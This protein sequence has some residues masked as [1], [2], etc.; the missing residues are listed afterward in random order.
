MS[1]SAV[2]GAIV[3][4]DLK[5]FSRDR[6][7]MFITIL[8]L[9][10]YVLIYWILPS[11]VDETIEVGVHGADLGPV[12]VVG[13]GEE[14]GLAVTRFSTADEL[15]Q[16]VLGEASTTVALGLDFPTDFAELV[17]SGQRATVRVLITPEVPAEYRQAMTAF[18]KEIAYG[19]AG[20]TAPVALPAQE[21]V[22][23]GE[24]RSGEQVSLQEKMGPMFV[25]F[26]LLVETFALGTLV[27]TELQGR[28]VT[29]ILATPARMSD[30]LTAKTVIGTLL[31]FTQALLLV[32]LIG[33][34]GTS[35]LV[36]VVVLL[37]GSLLVTGIGLIAGSTGKDF[38]GLVFWSMLF[39]IPLMVPAFAALFPGTASTWVRALPT[40]GLVE[41]IIR[42]TAFG[43]GMA[44]VAG[45]LLMLLGWC[46]VAFGAGLLMLRRRVAAL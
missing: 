28:T 11:N 26:I 27:A 41:T 25:F 1:R 38:V 44:D 6:F 18:V 40:Y 33:V 12:L 15:E 39:M 30:F 16:A 23:L 24:D 17:A 35:P 31:T 36:L 10:F 37:L 42:A 29:A 2:I 34:L 5:E 4:K 43:D 20:D 45:L 22:I 8:G 13:A 7:Y 14:Q 21:E 9:V 3:R 19:I 46:V 32:A